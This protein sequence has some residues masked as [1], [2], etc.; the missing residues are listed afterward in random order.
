[1][2][3]LFKFVLEISKRIFVRFDLL[4]KFKQL[5]VA[6]GWEIDLIRQIYLGLS[7][8]LASQNFLVSQVIEDFLAFSLLHAAMHVIHHVLE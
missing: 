3:G 1:L 5:L 6:G 7:I 4:I 8:L 2:K